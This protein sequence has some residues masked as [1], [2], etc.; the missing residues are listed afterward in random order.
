MKLSLENTLVRN[1]KKFVELEL[2][3]GDQT[4][5]SGKNGEGK[6]TIA[7]ILPYLLFNTDELGNKIDLTPVGDSV[8]GFAEG[9]VQIDGE[10]IKIARTTNKGANKGIEVN[11][12][13]MKVR[14]FETFLSE[15]DISKDV[16][17]SIYNPAYFFTLHWKKQR[18]LIF[19]AITKPY[20]SEVLDQLKERFAKALEEPLKKY[21]SIEDIKKWSS[22]Q[23]KNTKNEIERMRGRISVFE[24]QMK[25]TITEDEKRELQAK[26][27][28]LEL[29][30][31]LFDEAHENYNKVDIDLN[32]YSLSERQLKSDVQELSERFTNLKETENVCSV[33][34]GELSE[35]QKENV[36]ETLKSIA[37]EGKETESNLKEV[38][39]IKNKL[40]KQREKY[41]QVRNEYYNP[42]RNEQIFEYK[43]K[44]SQQ[45]SSTE[46]LESEKEKLQQIK[47]DLINYMDI[48]EAAIK[49]EQKEN[50][51]LRDKVNTLFDTIQVSIFEEQKNGDYKESFDVCIGEKKWYH[52]STGE[53]IRAG[54]EVANVI[55]NL[56]DFECPTFIDNAES[57]SGSIETS[58]QTILAY[59]SNSVL[60]VD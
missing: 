56:Y 24:K 50:E 38:I 1:Y 45:T 37:I 39:V 54:L 5:I 28:E 27:E 3:F 44:L 22:N 21:N 52:L 49:Y 57:V 17:L 34:G 14:E 31:R 58:R 51:M 9:M 13:P 33:C 8:S 23:V 42:T 40:L 41:E 2:N 16:F 43:L 47:K 4:K 46:Q 53:R 12:L 25:N 20:Q 7:S 10:R 15:K 35:E 19:N 6:S 60:E 32:K 36:K 59:V 55:S 48:E 29:S 11:G 26:L 18:E 30:K